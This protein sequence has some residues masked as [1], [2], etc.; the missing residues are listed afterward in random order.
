MLI[1]Y[2][3]TGLLEADINYL[4][5][6]S[7]YNKVHIVIW[8]GLITTASIQETVLQIFVEIQKHPLCFLCTTYIVMYVTG[9]NF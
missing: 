8:H 3:F 2:V 1:K 9:S 6:R 7:Y 4:Q 5:T